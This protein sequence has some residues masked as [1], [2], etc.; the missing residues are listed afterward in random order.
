MG[1]L[2]GGGDETTVDFQPTALEEDKDSL[3]KLR[4]A[5]FKTPGMSAGEELMEGG[6]SKRN[7]IF[8]N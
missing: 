7:T 1:F 5:L 8:G 6:V 2:F 4:S 3:K